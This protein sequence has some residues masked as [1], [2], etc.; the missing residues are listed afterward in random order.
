MLGTWIV[1]LPPLL[2]IASVL[3]TRRMILSFLVGIISSALIVKQANIFQ[4]LSLTS[5][6][7]WQ[8]TGLSQL[9]SIEGFLSNWNLMVF[10]FLILVGILI[11][12]LSKTGAAQAYVTIARRHVRTKKQAES[13]SLILSLFF[14]IDDYFSALTV[15]SVMRPLARQ[16]GVHPVKLA[17]LTTVMATPLAILSPISSWVGEIVLQLK[18]IGIG[19]IS[20]T[21]IVAADPYLVFV[22]TIAY[23]FYPIFLIIS[24]WYIV[25]RSISYGPMCKYDSE[26]AT[27]EAATSDHQ[28]SPTNSSLFD[29]LF[30]LGLLIATVFTM[31]LA[32]GGY[33]TSSVS[34]FESIKHAS[35]HQALF[36]G[37]LVSVTASSLY[38][39]AR[40]RLT[41][42]SLSGCIL[43]GFHSMFPSIIMLVCAWS[44]GNILKN[45]LQT[46][47]YVATVLAGIISLKL[48]PLVCF[49]FGALI[50]WLIGSAWAT[51]GLMFPIM[52]DMFQKLQHL[53]L[54]TPLEDAT[55][56]IPIIAATLSGCVLGTQLSLIS[57]NPIMSAAATGANHLEHVKTM[58]WYIIPVGI[59]T[60]LSFTLLGILLPVLT[61][62]ASLI[63]SLVFGLALSIIFLEIGQRLF[64]MAKD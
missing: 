33:F 45:D 23:G 26:P 34:L 47:A 36:T 17:F 43:E 22:N 32:T 4:A 62:S 54:N 6:K 27:H 50:A 16:Y 20:S 61:G 60:A 53:P 52:I 41:K 25:L 21:T 58:A 49:I 10:L 31:L 19:P 35:V 13:A 7:L 59:A 51:I 40:K 38:F 37:G 2:V 8:T 9:T 24:A 56:I 63:L 28:A 18:A 15:G 14:F 5:Q 44:L 64:G 29:F 48:F 57:D 55:L 12:M 39:L 3:L 46:G 11:E 30:P 1:I 42:P